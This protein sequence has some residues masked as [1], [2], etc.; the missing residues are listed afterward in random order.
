MRTSPPVAQPPH[1][2]PRYRHDHSRRRRRAQHYTQPRCRYRT[3]THAV[4]HP[5]LVVVT[6]SGLGST[7]P[8]APRRPQ[9]TPPS[10]T[11]W[12]QCVNRCAEIARRT[13]AT[14]MASKSRSTPHASRRH[15]CTPVRLRRRPPLSTPPLLLR[16]RPNKPRQSRRCW[17]DQPRLQRGR[18]LLKSHRWRRQLWRQERRPLC[19][20]SR[21]CK[22]RCRLVWT[23][24]PLAD[25]HGQSTQWV[26]RPPQWQ[27]H[28]SAT[29][30][31]RKAPHL[32]VR[33]VHE[34]TCT[35]SRV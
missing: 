1:Y 4:E 15:T 17:R 20:H 35:L 28:P 13:A 12:L 5:G 10:T 3:H 29:R 23:S 33:R 31:K 11:E 9:P 7:R 24:Q 18:L 27:V 22:H 16:W 2:P 30:A 19:R 14:A 32:P 21:H 8:R 25:W 26:P 6:P 34:R